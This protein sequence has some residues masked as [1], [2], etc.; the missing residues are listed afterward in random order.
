MLPGFSDN[1]KLAREYSLLGDYEAASICYSGTISQLDL[2]HQESCPSGS[3]KSKDIMSALNALKSERDLVESIREELKRFTTKGSSKSSTP[4]PSVPCFDSDYPSSDHQ[5]RHILQE[6]PPP[7]F[8]RIPDHLKNKLAH[9]R[10][11]RNK[12][13]PKEL[14]KPNPKR[15]Q[16]LAHDK[17]HKQP[18]QPVKSRL[19]APTAA[20]RGQAKVQ[21]PPRQSPERSSSPPERPVS[22]KFQTDDPAIAERIEREMIDRSVNTKM[23][24]VAGLADAKRVLHEAVILPRLRPDF[25]TGI[26]RPWKGILLHGPPGTG[27]TLLAKAV[28]NECGS[29]FF[30]VSASTLVNKLL[31][32]SEKTIRV[33]FEMARFYA[34]SIIFLDEIDAVFNTRGKSGEH[35]ASRR[36]KSQLLI[37]MEGLSNDQLEEDSCK[38]VMVLAATNFPWDL[39]EA[40]R[41]RLEKR[42]YIPLPDTEGRKQLLTDC[43]KDQKLAGAKDESSKDEESEEKSQSKGQ[44]YVDI[45]KLVEL[46]DGYSGA[47]LTNICRDASFSVIRKAIAGLSPEQIQH[48]DKDKVDT[49]HMSDFLDCLERI[50]P[51]VDKKDV[52]RHVLWANEFGSK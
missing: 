20:S 38:N 1:L 40:L 50:K 43:L 16:L 21:P 29:K 6:D 36:I 4:E 19:M 30:A 23:T 37:M 44:D 14:H 24:D 33:L 9:N 49:I 35:D 34:P 51:S 27:K 46:T 31:G 48:L 15:A 41:R 11:P 12:T 5:K 18:Q 47:D 42:V 10:P 26:R 17:R 13:P 22:P 25:F 39:D 7:P 32:E 2:F 8:R 3:Q 52:E 28:A 45:D